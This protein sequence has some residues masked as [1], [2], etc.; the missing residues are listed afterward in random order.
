[1][2]D[3]LLLPYVLYVIYYMYNRIRI[4]QNIKLVFLKVFTGCGFRERRQPLIHL[5][6][7]WA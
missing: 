2:N 5:G 6:H 4:K 1:M 3:S 7:I